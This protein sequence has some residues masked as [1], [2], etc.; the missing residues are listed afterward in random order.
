VLGAPFLNE[1]TRPAW[2]FSCD[3]FTV[4]DLDA[5]FPVAILGVEVRGRVIPEVQSDAN[6]VESAQFWH[7]D[8]FVDFVPERRTSFPVVSKARIEL[9]IKS[10]G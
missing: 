8:S 5:G 6:T 10:G 3:E 4:V 2:K 1:A 9:W 7:L